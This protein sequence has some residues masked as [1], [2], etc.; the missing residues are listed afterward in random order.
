LQCS[1]IGFT[2]LRTFTKDSESDRKEAG[3]MEHGKTA[4]VWDSLST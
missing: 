4:P 2:L 3:H 1:H